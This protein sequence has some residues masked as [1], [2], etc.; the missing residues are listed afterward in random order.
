MEKS[1]K[2]HFDLAED[3]TTSSS[4]QE[5][6]R[7]QNSQSELLLDIF[8]LQ[9]IKC[10]PSGHYSTTTYLDNK[11][12]YVAFDRPG[13]C[14]L[15]PE[16]TAEKAKP[17]IF[18]QGQ[19]VLNR[20]FFPCFDTLA[21]KSTYSAS[22][23]VNCSLADV[24][25][26][27]S[28]P[29]KKRTRFNLV[30]TPAQK[31]EYAY[32]CLIWIENT[33]Q[34]LK[35]FEWCLIKA[36]NVICIFSPPSGVDPDDTYNDMPYE[37][38][39]CFVSYL[40]HLVGDQ[41]CFDAFLKAYID[42]FKFCSV[43]AEDALE[44]FPE[45]KKKGVHKI[46]V[47]G[48]EFDSCL[49]VPGW[50]LY[51]PDL[52]AGQSLMKPAEQLSEL[53]AV[54]GLDMASIMKTNIQAWKTYQAIYFLEKI[55]EKSPLPRGN[56]EKQ[57]EQYPHIVKSN[58]AELRLRWAQIIA[59]NQHQPGYQHMRSFLICQGK[60]MYTLPVYRALWNGSEET[61]SLLH[62]NVRNYVKKIIA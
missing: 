38:G 11:I 35:L 47:K 40:A 34:F 30:I 23:K 41:C 52:S 57:E 44:Y 15:E 28:R 14:W 7:I 22:V 19:A 46:E 4:F 21:V 56:I 10:V 33:L 9:Q 62:V 27:F 25:V 24:I 60:Q 32:N 1:L 59:K 48:L 49:N 5:L 36:T 29:D 42:K 53:W 50:P 45:L 58:N 61:R 16:Q 20:S 6:K 12:H 3:V 8:I 54:E 26:L 31:L 39:F 17:Y 18:S 55:I 37:K 2:L 51:L 13:V 43:M